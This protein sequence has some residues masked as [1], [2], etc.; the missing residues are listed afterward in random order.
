[1]A[2][3]GKRD[4]VREGTP[5][6]FD[7]NN[8][9]HAQSCL[10]YRIPGW[11]KALEA[12]GKQWPSEIPPDPIGAAKWWIERQEPI[13][14]SERPKLVSCHQTDG[15]NRWETPYFNRI[16][17][18]MAIYVQL[19]D[20]S[21]EVILAA[22]ADRVFWRGEPVL[23]DDGGPGQFLSVYDETMRARETNLA[24]YVPE[25]CKR[26]RMVISGMVVR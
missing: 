3:L 23:S 12:A 20:K 2:R 5:F 24:E 25:V 14:P 13:K 8:P 16:Q 11:R 21:R 6:D 1:M 19:D 17:A 22:L 18:T 7:R 4:Q 10:A 15:G 9:P 26:M